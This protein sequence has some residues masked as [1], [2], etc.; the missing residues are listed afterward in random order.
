MTAHDLLLTWLPA[1]SCNC[2]RCAPVARRDHLHLATRRCSRGCTGVLMAAK[3]ESNPNHRSAPRAR[4]KPWLEIHGRRQASKPRDGT[5]IL[6]NGFVGRACIGRLRTPPKLDE[7]SS[8]YTFAVAFSEPAR[9]DV[10]VGRLLVS[11]RGSTQ[12]SETNHREQSSI[13]QATLESAGAR[14]P[15]S[16]VYWQR[17]LTLRTPGICVVRSARNSSPTSSATTPK[18]CRS[19]ARSCTDLTYGTLR[20]RLAPASW[21]PQAFDRSTAVGGAPYPARR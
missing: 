16:C 11:R 17:P 1:D 15:Y 12:S 13:G 8:C 18:T 20:S 4:Y 2:W 10:C 9:L 7:H 14:K 3:S 19:C 5:G 21:K 6:R